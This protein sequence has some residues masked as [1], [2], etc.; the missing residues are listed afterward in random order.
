[1]SLMLA[2]LAVMLNKTSLPFEMLPF[3]F[4]PVITVD[5]PCP[6]KEM[7][8]STVIPGTVVMSYTPA[9]ILIVSPLTVLVSS[10]A[11]W[12]D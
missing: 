1:M 6:T 4:A 10:I 8:L 3:L 2:S 12:I 5:D 7:S 9:E 11:N